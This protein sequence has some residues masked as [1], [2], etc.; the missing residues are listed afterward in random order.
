MS[1]L[2]GS[3]YLGLFYGLMVVGIYIS[4]RILNIPDLTTEGSF[5]FGLSLSALFVRS[6]HPYLGLLIATIGGF[7]AGCVTGWL[8]TK[9][10]I[11][12]ILAGI[13]TMTSLYSINLWVLGGANLSLI[14]ENTMVS[15]FRELL[16]QYDKDIVK[17]MI[18]IGITIVVTILMSMFFKTHFGLCIRAVGDNEE[19]LRASS[20]NVDATKIVAIGIANACVALS[21]GFIAQAQGYA[22]VNSGVGILIA[23][24]ASVII[25]E[26]IFGKRGVTIGLISALVGSIVYRLIIAFA[27]KYSVFPQSMFKLVSALIVAITLAM[28]TIGMLKEKHKIKIKGKLEMKIHR[29]TNNREHRN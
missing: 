12:P 4:F 10:K 7:F 17:L 16:P 22:D 9:L 23:G 11:H 29:E 18:A 14:G 1:L 28:P 21:G 15:H 25:G 19:M 3:L 5:V 26:A 2:I 8:Q 20:V 6:G 24:L 13:L 27:L